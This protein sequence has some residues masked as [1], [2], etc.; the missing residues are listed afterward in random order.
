MLVQS[1]FC[2]YTW[3]VFLLSVLQA[4]LR[5]PG[6]HV[7]RVAHQY[8]GKVTTKALVKVC[9][10]CVCSGG[11]AKMLLPLLP[12]PLTCWHLSFLTFNLAKRWLDAPLMRPIKL[13]SPERAVI[14]RTPSDKAIF[15][16]CNHD[17]HGRDFKKRAKSPVGGHI[18]CPPTRGIKL[19]EVER[20]RE[21]KLQEFFFFF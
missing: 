19:E 16:L 21:D 7:T 20:E 3:A 17:N 12:P 9:M 6:P 15:H 5:V 13:M 2:S 4:L 11:N 8:T 1:S 18:P 14:I 10:R